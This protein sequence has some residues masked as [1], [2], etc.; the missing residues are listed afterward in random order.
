MTWPRCLAIVS[1]AYQCYAP[2]PPHVRSS[3]PKVKTPP[4]I[5]AG[6]KVECPNG[7]YR[8]MRDVDAIECRRRDGGG[9]C[10]YHDVWE[11]PH[12]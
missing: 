9:A 10:T 4:R 6:C 5:Y 1:V 12:E 7:G 11:A 8:L 2:T 3:P